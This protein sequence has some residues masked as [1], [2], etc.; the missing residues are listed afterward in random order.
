MRTPQ[1]RIR[2]PAPSVRPRAPLSRPQRARAAAVPVVIIVPTLLC[3]GASWLA[4]CVVA[5][6]P[7]TPAASEIAAL[8]ALYSATKGIN[9]SVR[10]GWNTLADPC[11]AYGVSCDASGHV[12]YGV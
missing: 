12:R 10:S 9:W 11:S 3:L 8:S 2:D 4:R 7:L 6:A 1:R 5:A